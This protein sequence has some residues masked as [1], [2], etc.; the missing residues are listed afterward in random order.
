MLSG[1]LFGS[2]FN[3]NCRNHLRGLPASVCMALLAG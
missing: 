3:Y 1:S 2:F